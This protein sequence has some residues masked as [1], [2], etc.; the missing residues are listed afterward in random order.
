[1]GWKFYTADGSIKGVGTTGATGATGPQGFFF[2]GRDGDDGQDSY[3]PGPRGPAGGGVAAAVSVSKSAGQTIPNITLTAIT[4]DLEN[5]DTDSIHSVSSNTSRFVVP[6]GLSGK[7]HVWASTWFNLVL[8]GTL[9]KINVTIN[10]IA[11][12]VPVIE[13]T[14][15][16]SNTPSLILNQTFDLAVGDYV[17][18]NVYQ[19]S[20]GNLDIDSAFTIGGMFRVTGQGASGADSVVPGPQGP[21]GQAIFGEDGDDGWP[22]PGPQGSPGVTGADSTV[23]GP[24]GPQGPIGQA[25][26]GEDGDDGWPGPPGATGTGGTGAGG[27]WTTV[28]KS[29]NESV[30]NSSVFQNDNELFFTV[31]DN[32][33]Y[34]WELDIVCITASAS[35]VPDI[36][37]KSA[38]FN[39]NDQGGMSISDYYDTANAFTSRTSAV[40]GTTFTAS[41]GPNSAKRQIIHI[42]AWITVVGAAGTMDFQWAQNTSDTNATTV[43]AGSTLRWRKLAV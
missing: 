34:V 5:Y 35:G 1:M 14:P 26:F 8:A 29:A 12:G 31:D 2:P 25:I 43:L 10:G 20:G 36:K 30:T 3:M 38:T 21:L 15:V 17:E 41:A 13:Y 6:P 42:R 40:L 39:A 24:T 33:N 28:V 18:I 4:W 32:G 9:M 11:V 7:W 23:P 19:A 37:F 22:L 27:Y 16:N